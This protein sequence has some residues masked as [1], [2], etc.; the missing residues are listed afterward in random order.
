LKELPYEERLKKLSIPSLEYRRNRADMIQVYRIFSGLDKL[1]A[2]LFFEM[3]TS[4]PTRGHTLKIKKH[5][6]STRL[7]QKSFSQR[8]V[9]L[10]NDLPAD[11]VTAGS[12]NIFKNGLEKYW[13][14]IVDKYDP[15]FIFA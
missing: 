13:L 9:N 12:I 14:T 8:I 5:H 1:D 15:N 4:G 11:L 7:R 10:W 6:I 2:S 3:N